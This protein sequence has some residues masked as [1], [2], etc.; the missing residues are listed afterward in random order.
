MT[1]RT[2]GA[3]TWWRLAA[4]FA[5]S[6]GGTLAAY[7]AM[8][9]TRLA[10]AEPPEAEAPPAPSAEPVEAPSDSD[11]VGKPVDAPDALPPELRESADNNVSFPVD[12]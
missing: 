9:D 10:Q 11:T 3:T 6:L 2:N 7:A 8:R 12:I 1:L 5:L 4:V